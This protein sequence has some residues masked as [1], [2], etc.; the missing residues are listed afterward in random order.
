MINLNLDQGCAQLKKN[1]QEKSSL[2]LNK[3]N[4][5]TNCELTKFME[6]ILEIYNLIR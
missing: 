2:C 6:C 5:L 1:Q 3:I 4:E